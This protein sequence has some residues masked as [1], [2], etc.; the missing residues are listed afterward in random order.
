MFSGQKKKIKLK[1]SNQKNTRAPVVSHALRISNSRPAYTQ[2][3]VQDHTEKL[4]KILSEAHMCVRVCMCVCVCLC[5]Y[6]CMYACMYVCMYV[7]LHACIKQP[8][9]ITH[10]KNAYLA[11]V[12]PGF[13]L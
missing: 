2:E 8:G 1:T 9:D 5:M 13:N 12:S 6:V 11:C 4:S 10:W 7:F 3:W